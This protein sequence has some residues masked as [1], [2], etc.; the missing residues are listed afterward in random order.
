M[1]AVLGYRHSVLFAIEKL[2]SNL[3]TKKAYSEVGGAIKSTETGAGAFALKWCILSKQPEMVKCLTENGVQF[4]HLS[5]YDLKGIFHTIFHIDCSFDERGP[6]WYPEDYDDDDLD[7]MRDIRRYRASQCYQEKQK[8]LSIII[9]A[10]IPRDLFIPSNVCF[11]A[12]K[13]KADK[14][15]KAKGLKE[16]NNQIWKQVLNADNTKDEQ[17]CIAVMNEACMEYNAVTVREKRK[18]IFEFVQ[19]VNDLFLHESDGSMQNS[20]TDEL[21]VADPRWVQRVKNGG[22]VCPWWEEPD[23]DEEDYD[24]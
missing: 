19:H 9:D 20:S 5:N 14:I 17:R 22:R 1:S 13:E 11:D 2:G 23:S 24:Y 4:R 18:S 10:G 16:P 8:M 3:H 6:L 7:S 21:E 15:S 12:I